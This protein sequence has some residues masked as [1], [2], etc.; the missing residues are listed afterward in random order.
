[1]RIEVQ[2]FVGLISAAAGVGIVAGLG[3]ALVA[4]GALVFAD[5]VFSEALV[6]K[7]GVNTR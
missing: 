1:M 7:F 3:W 2:K 4:F 5:A 6:A